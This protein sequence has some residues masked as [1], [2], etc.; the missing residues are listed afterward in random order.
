MAHKVRRLLEEQD[1]VLIQIDLKNGFGR[2]NRAHLFKELDKAGDAIRPLAK[3]AR[4]AYGQTLRLSGTYNAGERCGQ[5]FTIGMEHG[6]I[7]GD[8]TAP[9]LFAFAIKGALECAREAG[10]KVG[11]GAVYAY[12]DDVS[13][14]GPPGYVAAAHVAFKDALVG[15]GGELNEAKTVV[16]P[17]TPPAQ[18]L[19]EELG[20]GDAC[21]STTLLGMHLSDLSTVRNALKIKIDG[22]FC[23]ASRASQAAGGD[24]HAG[25]AE[26][27]HSLFRAEGLSRAASSDARGGEGLY[28]RV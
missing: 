24:E 21:N 19:A 5:P 13:G 3:F 14:V 16:Y 17:N 27:F 11:K 23:R 25:G 6:V 8:P 9:A 10:S 4:V 12:I 7:Q 20:V 26:T 15:T 1:N 18:Q 2:V 28:R 22:E